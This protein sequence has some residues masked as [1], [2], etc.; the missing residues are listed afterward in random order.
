[1][2]KILVTGATGQLGAAVVESLLQKI[3]ADDI[4]VLVRDANKASALKVR[5][6]KVV[7]GDYDDYQSLVNAFNDIEKVYLVSSNDI[8]NRSTQQA[9]VIKAAKETGVKH[10]VYTS[11]QHKNETPTSPIL[12]IAQSH[13]DTENGLKE[14]GL[15]YTILQ[16]G[17]YADIIPMFAGEHLL[18]NEIIYLPAGDGKT[19]YA[20]RT[21]FAEA[22]A[23][24]L[25]D[26]T[27]KFHN[28]T[29]EL[30]GS[31]AISWEEI[32][33]IISEI[34]GKSIKYVS[35]T[36]DEF[37]NTLA[38]TGVP[39]EVIGL[40]AGFGGGMQEGEFDN[41]TNELEELLGRKPVTV[42][43]YLQSVYKS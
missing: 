24:I 42:K 32:A 11:F 39:A 9:Q 33:A 8:A 3:S 40:L 18:E 4:T 26:Q 22:G 27:D 20:L 10:I 6:V 31:Q 5:G 25:T 16:H 41:I 38:K 43:T 23:L 17:L 30:A 34:T 19:A 21:D 35:P 2:S 36:K 15:T 12:A 29:L 14:S 37:V 13:L 7:T 1:M 28:K